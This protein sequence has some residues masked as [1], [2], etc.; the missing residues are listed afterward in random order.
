MLL[1][2]FSII[3]MIVLIWASAKWGVRLIYAIPTYGL[4]LWAYR[5][6]TSMNGVSV[7]AAGVV[8]IFTI[9]AFIIPFLAILAM[10]AAKIANPWMFEGGY[11]DY[12]RSF[13]G[14]AVIYYLY[15]NYP[16]IVRKAFFSVLPLPFI[17]LMYMVGYLDLSMKPLDDAYIYRGLYYLNILLVLALGIGVVKVIIEM[18]EAHRRLKPRSTRRL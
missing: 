2:L 1:V 4:I 9:I 13:L 7:S 15:D 16:G 8:F 17:P 12:K 14:L 18:V 3:Y 5:D 6:I 11:E 10:E